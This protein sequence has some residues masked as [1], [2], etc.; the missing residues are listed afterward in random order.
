MVLATVC[1]IFAVYFLVIIWARKADMLDERKVNFMVYACTSYLKIR[2]DYHFFSKWKYYWCQFSKKEMKKTKKL[3][4][5]F[6]DKKYG[7]VILNSSCLNSV[8]NY[9]VRGG[10]TSEHSQSCHAHML[11]HSVQDTL[12]Q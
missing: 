12:T 5:R 10:F 4:V 11:N 1:T 3:N 9:T 7:V 2:L 6:R 8:T